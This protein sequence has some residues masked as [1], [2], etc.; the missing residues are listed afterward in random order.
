MPDAASGAPVFA[1]Y[2]PA[3]REQQLAVVPIGPGRKPYVNS[4]NQWRYRPG[5]KI[6]DRWCEVFGTA[7]IGVLPGLSKRRAQAALEIARRSHGQMRARRDIRDPSYSHGQ[8]ENHVAPSH[9]KSADV[10]AQRA[11]DRAGRADDEHCRWPCACPISTSADLPVSGRRRGGGGSL[12]TLWSESD[13]GLGVY[14]FSIQLGDG[15]TFT[16]TRWKALP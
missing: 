7:N 4:F 8:G 15:M 13:N 10:F 6:V 16:R 1:T 2:A 5:A 14:S 3:M 12:V 11:S 9:R